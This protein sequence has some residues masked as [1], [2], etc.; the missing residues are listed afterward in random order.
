MNAAAF[1]ARAAF[2][3]RADHGRAGSERSRDRISPIH[4]AKAG[5]TS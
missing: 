4:N 1:L 5:T 3:G 2:L